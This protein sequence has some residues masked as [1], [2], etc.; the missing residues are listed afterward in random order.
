MF[1]LENLDDTLPI[2]F[3]ASNLL[4]LMLSIQLYLGGQGRIV[5][6]F[7][8]SYYHHVRQTW[9]G[10]KDALP[11]LPLSPQS[12]NTL[13]GVLMIVTCPIVAWDETRRVGA[14]MT[15]GLTA[16]KW[17]TLKAQGASYVVP[18]INMTLSFL[19]LLCS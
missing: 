19:M 6:V 1:G 9:Q 2:R 4:A 14:L 7:T 12:L 13:L 15:V 18:Q 11:F 17:Y 5:P 10:T 8:T 16:V 3:S